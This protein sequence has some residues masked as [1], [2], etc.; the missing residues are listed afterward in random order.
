MKPK[1]LVND[2]INDL[3]YLNIPF[4]DLR[5]CNK[6][7]KNHAGSLIEKKVKNDKTSYDYDKTKRNNVEIIFR[8]KL[9]NY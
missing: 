1:L 5:I 2:L 8:I 6:E 7:K 9:Y 4:L 3:G